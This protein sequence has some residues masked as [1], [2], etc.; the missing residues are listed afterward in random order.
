[1]YA[2][3]FR[4]RDKDAF[5]P[6]SPFGPPFP[7]CCLTES[8][9]WVFCMAYAL[10]SLT[11]KLSSQNSGA[12]SVTMVSGT[13]FL[14]NIVL[15]IC[16]TG[17]VFLSRTFITSGQPKK[18]SSNI[19]NKPISR[20]CAWSIWTVVHSAPS[21][22]HVYI[23]VCL[24]VLISVHLVHFKCVSQH[25]YNIPATKS[26]ISVFFESQRL[27][28]GYRRARFLLRPSLKLEASALDIIFFFLLQMEPVLP[29]AGL[30]ISSE[31]T[32]AIVF[33]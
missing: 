18:E 12:L 33:A 7:Q 8:D 29:K 25:L 6:I 28:H 11:T 26:V 2:S 32:L 15:N 22:D 17:V 27:R 31:M 21:L 20:T 9:M 4:L 30:L 23:L 13:S 3:I 19:K 1:M 5:K 14:A 10:F 24:D 16:I